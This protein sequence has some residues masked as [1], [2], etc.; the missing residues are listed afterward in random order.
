[1]DIEFRALV[2]EDE[3]AVRELT[4]RALAARGFQCTKARDGKEALVHL[5]ET[6]YDVVVSD[7]RMPN[8][9]GHRLVYEISRREDRPVVV[10]VTGV[11][12]PGLVGSVLNSGADDI[13]FKPVDYAVLAVK[14]RFLVE[15]RRARDLVQS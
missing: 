11:I 4:A 15:Q 12:D 8:L 2:V 13:M 1:M 10:V 6:S 5:D 14:V 3:P 9:N 7:F